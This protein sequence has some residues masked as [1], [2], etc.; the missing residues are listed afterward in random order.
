MLDRSAGPSARG[1][2]AM[3]ALGAGI[4]AAAAIFSDGR[5]WVPICAALAVA[6]A[7]LGARASRMSA[8]ARAAEVAQGPLLTYA[9]WGRW[10]GR[11]R[12]WLRRSLSRALIAA[13]YAPASRRAVPDILIC[14]PGAP[15]LAGWTP[16]RVAGFVVGMLPDL[17]APEDLGRWVAGLLRHRSWDAVVYISLDLPRPSATLVDIHGDEAVAT[18]RADDDAFVRALA[19]LLIERARGGDAGAAGF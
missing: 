1:S 17:R 11:R 15:R 14:G 4:I 18:G 12:S 6:G 16:R 8:T 13:G 2:A 10:E 9:I 7:L 5:L 3:A 19:R